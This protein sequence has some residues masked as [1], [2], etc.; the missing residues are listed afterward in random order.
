MTLLLSFGGFGQNIQFE[1]LVGVWNC[2]KVIYLSGKDS[3]DCTD[4]FSNPI[5]TYNMDRSYSENCLVTNTDV[6]GSYT[7]DRTKRVISYQDLTMTT[8]YK[9]VVEVPDFVCTINRRDLIILKLESE[10]MI[11][12]QKGMPNSETPNDLFFYLFK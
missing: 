6:V 4:Q 11:L 9:G 1:E 8:K 7:L 3:V 10:R 12:F 2:D 5:Y